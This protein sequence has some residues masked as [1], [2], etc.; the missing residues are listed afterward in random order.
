M[1]YSIYSFIDE[2]QFVGAWLHRKTLSDKLRSEK[3]KAESK[4]KSESAPDMNVDAELQEYAASLTSINE[5]LKTIQFL[6]DEERRL[7]GETEAAQMQLQKAMKTKKALIT[8]AIVVAITIC[9]AVAVL[10]FM[11]PAAPTE[12]AGEETLIENV[13]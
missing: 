3:V 10:I 4:I 12:Q 11:K 9:I 1:A 7:N 2:N 6:R 8:F 13:Q 5:D